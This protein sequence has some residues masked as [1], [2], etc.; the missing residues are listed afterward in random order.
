MLQ[1][2]GLHTVLLSGLMHYLDF[3]NAHMQVATVRGCAVYK[4]TDTQSY[5]KWHLNSKQ[6]D[7]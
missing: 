4:V 7:R 5:G 6:D 3:V 1:S 2:I